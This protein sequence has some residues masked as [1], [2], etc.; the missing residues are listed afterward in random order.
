MKKTNWAVAQFCLVVP[1]LLLYDLVLIYVDAQDAGTI[2]LDQKESNVKQIAL[3]AELL[4]GNCNLLA[5]C[6]SACTRAVCYPLVEDQQAQCVRV[7]L[8]DICQPTEFNSS[9]DHFMKLNYQR[10]YLTLPPPADP[11]QLMPEMARDICLQRALDIT[12]KTVSSEKEFSYVYFGS[13]S[14]VFRAFPGRERPPN[15][16]LSFE[17]RHRPWFKNGNSVQKQ[18]RILVDTGN[19]M[20]SQVPPAYPPEAGKTFLEVASNIIVQL[21]RTL[22]PDDFVDVGLFN[23]SGYHQLSPMVQITTDPP[24]DELA[25]MEASVTSNLTRSLPGPPSN[26]T[27]AIV[28][29]VKTFK[30]TTSETLKVIVIFTDGQFSPLDATTFPTAEIL[31]LKLKIILYKLPRQFDPDP[32]LRLTTLNNILC[33]AKGTFELLEPH[34]TSNP[35]FSIRS[36]YTFLARTHLAVAKNQ[37]TWSSVYTG[38]SQA[39]NGTTVT[40]PAFG[41]DGQLI[42]IAGIDVFPDELDG[43]LRDLVRTAL[44]NR[45]SMGYLP[46]AFAD[47]NLACSYQTAAGTVESCSPSAT[48]GGI[49]EATDAATSLKQRVC[50]AG[51]GAP[52]TIVSPPPEPSGIKLST[53]LAAIFGSLFGVVVTACLCFCPFLKGRKTLFALLFR[54]REKTM[55]FEFAGGSFREGS[56][57][58]AVTAAELAAGSTAGSSSQGESE[59]VKG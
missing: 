2:F 34:T 11:E 46:G 39:L 4:D 27:A 25:G 53:L 36:F 47:I 55:D 52:P 22:S 19:S 28:N 3:S 38:I 41:K 23:S 45:N 29:V 15:T 30:E 12:F 48:N 13:L 37:S 8:N 33:N 31:D 44:D 50:C 6:E 40:Y 1:C 51:C 16:C 24:S 32:F 17:T 35:L 56:T 43:P 42:G 21:I 10:S 54:R 18:L 9:C 14:G 49:C 57:V 26:L 7:N 59:Y 5:N 58:A 20:G